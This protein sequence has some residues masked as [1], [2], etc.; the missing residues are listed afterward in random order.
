M[1]AVF[2]EVPHKGGAREGAGRKPKGYQK[3]QEVIDFER[4]R[5]RNEAAKAQKNEIDV[6]EAL[7]HLVAR[8]AV[9]AAVAT[10]MANLG[11]TLRTIPDALERRGIPVQVC[12]IVQSVIEEAM[13]DAAQQMESMVL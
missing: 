6:Q 2:D 12:V 5:A 13:R 9:E 10:T 3:A 7:G 8:D 1:S 11:Q 4:A